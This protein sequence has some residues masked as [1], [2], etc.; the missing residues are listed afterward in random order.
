MSAESPGH[1]PRPLKTC[2]ERACVRRSIAKSVS[3]QCK[4]V[5]HGEQQIRCR[6]G[7]VL[8]ECGEPLAGEPRHR[9]CRSC[10]E[11]TAAY[12]GKEEVA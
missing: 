12:R 3:R 1:A 2:G 11:K 9:G 5:K 4:G 6:N 7:Q 10:Q 8:C